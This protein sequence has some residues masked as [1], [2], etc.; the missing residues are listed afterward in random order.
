M[1]HPA[2]QQRP[3]NEVTSRMGKARSALG[4]AQACREQ[5]KTGIVKQG[6]DFSVN[7]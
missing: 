4:S 2:G 1:Q 5:K 7:T 3:G 6:D